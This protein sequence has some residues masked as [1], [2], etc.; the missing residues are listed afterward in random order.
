MAISVK[1]QTLIFLISIL[2]GVA[3]SIF[4]DMFRAFRRL[5]KARAVWVS[6][7]DLLFWLITGFSVFLFL[8]RINFG[9][10]RWYIF[11]GIGLGIFFYYLAFRNRIVMLLLFLA[12]MLLSILRF[13]LRLLAL[14][15]RFLSRL[16]RPVFFFV[17]TPC[18]ALGRRCRRL[19]RAFWRWARRDGKKLK[20][21]LKMY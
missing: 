17:W 12:R 4:F 11:F 21:R 6:I 20:K 9:E 2:V 8:Y 3:G 18:T 13:C 14:P 5:V 1:E 15:L 16:M 19:G 7:Q 10:V